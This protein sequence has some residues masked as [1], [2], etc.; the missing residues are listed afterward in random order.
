MNLFLL[1]GVAGLSHQ[2]FEER[3]IPIGTVY[4]PFVARS[5]DA[6]N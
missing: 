1:L 6:L 4:D 2:L 5:L 3:L